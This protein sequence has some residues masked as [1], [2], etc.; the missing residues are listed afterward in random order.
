M[1]QI[2]FD[3]VSFA[4]DGIIAVKDLNFSLHPRDYLLIVGDNGSGKSTLLKGLLR[5]KSPSMGSISIS[6][7][8]KY[9]EIGYLPQ[10]TD[11]QKDFP[12]G[13][14]EVVLSGRLSAHKFLPFYTAHDRSTAR[15]ALSFMGIAELKDKSY[16]DLSGGQQQRVLLARALCAAQKMLVLDEPM[17]GLDPAATE[18]LYGFIDKLNREM[19]MTV[20]MVSHDVRGALNHAAKVLHLKNKQIFYGTTKEYLNSPTGKNFALMGDNTCK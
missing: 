17:S 16:R 15:D 9:N 12:A 10:Q 5:L 13:V 6:A 3:N 4:Y 7:G 18:E 2:T 8:L 20:V 1:A 11:I 14:F 19:G